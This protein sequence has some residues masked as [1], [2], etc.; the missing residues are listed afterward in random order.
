MYEFETIFCTY[1]PLQKQ[2][3]LRE[4]RNSEDADTGQSRFLMSYN[5]PLV[6]CKIHVY[7]KA[8]SLSYLIHK[9]LAMQLQ[10]LML[11]K[12]VISN[13]VVKNGRES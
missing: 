5:V 4:A 8:F 11:L 2:G 7:N 3:K 1:F 6:F 9:S 13:Y 12:I 10:Q